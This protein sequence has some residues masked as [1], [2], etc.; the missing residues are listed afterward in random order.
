MPRDRDAPATRGGRGGRGGQGGQVSDRGDGAGGKKAKE[1]P[2]SNKC[3]IRLAMWDFAQCD[4]T[5]CSGKKL[6]RA[7]ALSVLAVKTPF[8]GVVLT[9]T[10]TQVV[11]AEDT[12]VMR[13]YGAAV[14]DCSWKELDKVPWKQMKMGAPRLLP[15]MVAANPVNYG[16]PSKLCCA[17]ALAAAMDVC[18]FVKEAEQVLDHFKWGR[19]FFEVNK[20][21]LDGYRSCKTADEVMAFQTAFLQRSD[22]ESQARR[23]EGDRLAKATE[24]GEVES[25]DSLDGL[26]P[27]NAKTER[28]GAWWLEDEE[29]SECCEGEEEEG[30]EGEAEEEEETTA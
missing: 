5:R 10:A 4:P 17:E 22:Q 7:G 19:S 18:G 29:S 16:R 3:G 13:Q 27:L 28:K 12:E 11:S 1:N 23:D 15:F 30:E 14:V 9:P 20:E 6:E 25:I 8:R 21:V 2:G 26:K 24:A